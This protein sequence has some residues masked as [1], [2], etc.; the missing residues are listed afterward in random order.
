[1]ADA[2]AASSAFATF[3]A[4]MAGCHTQAGSPNQAAYSIDSLLSK[5]HSDA[6]SPERHTEDE[7]T[8]W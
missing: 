7:P 1:M 6:S 8:I 2:A 5:V 4:M 3:A